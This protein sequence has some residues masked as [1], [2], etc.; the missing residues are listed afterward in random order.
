[1][2]NSKN[3]DIV[4]LISQILEYT[5]DHSS[6]GSQPGASNEPRPPEC[7]CKSENGFCGDDPPV[8]CP[9]VLFPTE[10]LCLCAADPLMKCPK[11]PSTPTCG[12]K[13][14]GDGPCGDDTSTCPADEFGAYDIASCGGFCDPPV[15]PKCWPPT[16]PTDTPTSSP[17][18]C[19]CFDCGYT[20]FDSG[21]CLKVSCQSGDCD[22]PKDDCYDCPTNS[23]TPSCDN[24]VPC[25]CDQGTDCAN[26]AGPDYECLDQQTQTC[27]NG[28]EVTCGNCEPVKTQTPTPETPTNTDKCPCD[29]STHASMQ[30]CS[31]AKR[32][33]CNSAFTNCQCEPNP[34][35][36]EDCL[37]NSE[38]T[39]LII[40]PTRTPTPSE[41]ATPTCPQNCEES[42]CRNPGACNSG[43]CSPFTSDVAAC[44]KSIPCGVTRCA[45]F[46]CDYCVH[47]PKTCRDG[48]GF[49]TKAAC[50]QAIFWSVLDRCDDCG[51][52]G[53]CGIFEP[54]WCVVPIPTDS[55]TSTLT[56]CNCENSGYTHPGHC[57]HATCENVDIVCPDGSTIPCDICCTPT[58][59]STCV[60]QNPCY[61]YGPD[62]QSAKELI[63]NNDQ[64]ADCSCDLR[65]CS[66]DAKKECT[67]LTCT[68]IT[69]T[70]ETQSPTCA[71]RPNG[72]CQEGVCA[73][74][75]ANCQKCREWSEHRKVPGDDPRC[76]GWDCYKKEITG[77]SAFRRRI[78]NAVW[79]N[80]TG[81]MDCNAD[82]V[83]CTTST[84]ILCRT[85]REALF[86][87]QN[88]R[89]PNDGIS[90]C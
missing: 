36:G 60:C 13:D 64:Y 23:P 22:P 40:N 48:G 53:L 33:Y 77:S 3:K 7:R 63:E 78:G 79:N 46:Q 11:C 86:G 17:E 21:G 5:E 20:A 81:R 85:Y 28:C 37:T 24:G 57:P 88:D 38:C 62:C 2:D 12:C 55:P 70:P 84:N 9:E 25:V 59:S 35:D 65:A 76:P 52:T 54:C 32:K 69:P 41:S 68:Y 47:Q 67:C 29:C 71:E 27:S 42:G 80:Q 74:K 8:D 6:S 31:E 39:D 45:L 34:C 66:S 15:C 75:N 58:P 18:P 73:G 56:P 87:L 4:E 89:G 30:A 19:Y 1:M 43:N 61:E 83:E 82:G 10:V 72:C 90:N 16:P 26:C 51:T 44:C 49:S 50:E 14:T